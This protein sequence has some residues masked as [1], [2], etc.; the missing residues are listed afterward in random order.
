VNAG[1]SFWN[2]DLEPAIASVFQWT[3]FRRNSG[4]P[5]EI[6][7]WIA[8]LSESS[9]VPSGQKEPEAAFSAALSA[10]HKTRASGVVGLWPTEFTRHKLRHLAPCRRRHRARLYARIFQLSRLT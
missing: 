3:G 5:V 2:L 8:A 7:C 6:L 1:L 10:V 4:L 9:A